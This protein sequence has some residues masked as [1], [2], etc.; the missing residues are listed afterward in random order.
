MLACIFM[1][2]GPA[3]H[4]Q[5]A[6]FRRKMSG[7]R[8]FS[9][10]LR[11]QSTEKSTLDSYDYS[12]VFACILALFLSIITLFLHSCIA[13]RIF[14]DCL[15][16]LYGDLL[17]AERSFMQSFLESTKHGTTFYPFQIY[18]M[19]VPPFTNI[20]NYHWHPELEILMIHKGT[21]IVTDNQV[22][23]TGTAGDLL[24]IMPEH[25]HTM[26]SNTDSV[27]YDAFVF[28]MEFL[29][30]A[31]FDEVQTRYLLPLVQKKLLFPPSVTDSCPAYPEIWSCFSSIIRENNTK[32]TAYPFSTKVLLLQIFCRMFQNNLF[33][34][35]CDSAVSASSEHL[36]LLREILTYI[37]ENYKKRLTL[38]DLAEH[39]H[40][41]PKYFSRYFHQNFGKTFT[42]YLN[43]YRIL[44]AC[45]LLLNTDDPVLAIALSTGFENVSYFIRKFKEGIGYTPSAYRTLGK[46]GK[47]NPASL[48]TLLPVP[49]SAPHPQNN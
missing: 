22:S 38:S 10:I 30:F 17:T 47:I 21:L 24:F 23:R 2:M 5:A 46:A 14:Q 18:H 43:D 1:S 37:S 48:Q 7:L 16:L 15:S 11:V 9:S 36:S 33:L 12:K 13:S 45:E 6:I 39:F 41:S 4:E 35:A 31:L 32:S 8:M 3:K 25:L 26:H 42:G 29:N 49:E 34:P 44:R 20:V 27:L 28:P 40:L 19:D